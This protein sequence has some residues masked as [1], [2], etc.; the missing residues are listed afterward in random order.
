MNNVNVTEELQMLVDTGTRV[1]GLRRKV[2]VDIDRLNALGEDLRTSVPADILEAQEILKQKES[3]VNQAYLEAQRIRTTAEQE[4]AAMKDAAHQEHVAKVDQTE[5]V[6]AAEEKGEEIKDQAMAEAQKIEQDAQRRVF[7][8]MSEAETV[9]NSRRE[10]ADQYAR[11]ILFSLEEHLAKL[12]GQVRRG[13]DVLRLEEAEAQQAP[14]RAQ[15]H[16]Q[17]PE[18]VEVP[19]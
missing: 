4:A 8:M 16:E 11:E 18:K 15:V 17:E 10:G 14:V 5:I 2:L 13:I 6:K 3:I 1:P 7:R 9:A 12:L 19:A